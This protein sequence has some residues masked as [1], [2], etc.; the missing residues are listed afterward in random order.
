MSIFVGLS[1]YGASN[2]SGVAENCHL[3]FFVVVIFFDIS[4]YETSMSQ[5]AVPQ[6][7]LLLRHVSIEDLDKTDRLLCN[8]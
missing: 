8:V 7:L 3:C 1:G 2:G 6:W 4:N 5:Y